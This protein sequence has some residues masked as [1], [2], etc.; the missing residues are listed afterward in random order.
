MPTRTELRATFAAERA[1]YIA[2][3]IDSSL[4]RRQPAPRWTTLVVWYE[5]DET[6]LGVIGP[7]EGRDVDIALAH[8]LHLTKGRRL[9]L[10]LPVEWAGPTLHRA[11]WLTTHLD[12]HVYDAASRVTTPAPLTHEKSRTQAGDAEQSPPLH[13]GK[14]SPDVRG[15]MSWA[16]GHADLDPAH[17]RDLRA[18]SCLGQRVLVINGK[19]KI[20]VRAGVDAASAGA[21]VWTS[22]FGDTFLSEVRAAVETGIAHAKRKEYGEFAEHHL[23]SL[24]RRTPSLLR[25]EHPLLREVPAW[26]PA[27]GDAAPL[28]RG[29]ID[30]LGLDGTGDVVVVE[31]KLAADDMLVL[32]GL[33]YWIW[34]TSPTNATWLRKRLHADAEKA[35]MKLLFAVGAKSGAT[36]RVGKYAQAHFDALLPEIPWQLAL[37]S[38]WKSE[39]MTVRLLPPRV[40]HA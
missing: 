16:A 17:R 14:A 32:Q 22:P 35:E 9:R 4:T 13:L 11:P 33:D 19:K 23:Q 25:L 7:Q 26:R 20:T 40:W 5:S 28:G 2:T 21:S 1:D 24:L 10:G 12:T 29:F 30:L 6:L 31:T 18:W 15:L 34:A 3:L 38:D 27:G 37:L 8:G 36:P 39:P